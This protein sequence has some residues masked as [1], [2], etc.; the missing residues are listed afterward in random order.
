MKHTICNEDEQNCHIQGQKLS[1]KFLTARTRFVHCYWVVWHNKCSFLSEDTFT[2]NI[3]LDALE[4]FF[5]EE[6]DDSDQK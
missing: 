1:H 5:L 3:I 2:A 6:T 4:P